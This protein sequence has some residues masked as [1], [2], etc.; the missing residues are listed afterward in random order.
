LSI[1]DVHG[2][3][4]S[5]LRGDGPAST[6]TAFYSE[7]FRERKWRGDWRLVDGVWRARFVAGGQRG[8]T[9]EIEIMPQG[10]VERSRGDAAGRAASERG[11]LEQSTREP[12]ENR[13]PGERRETD[14]NTGAQGLAAFVSIAPSDGAMGK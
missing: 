13:N 8:W 12:G 11:G 9:A 14:Q 10:N 4:L 1:E 7:W 5:A 6:W 2:A 3:G